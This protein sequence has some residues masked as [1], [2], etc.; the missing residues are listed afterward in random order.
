[1]SMRGSPVSDLSPE[2]IFVGR[3]R[4]KVHVQSSKPQSTEALQFCFAEHQLV[5]WMHPSCFDKVESRGCSWNTC[6]CGLCWLLGLT[7]LA[8]DPFPFSVLHFIKLLAGLLN[9]WSSEAGW[10]AV[11][12]VKVMVSICSNST[13]I[14]KY[15]PHILKLSWTH[16]NIWPSILP[17]TSPDHHPINVLE[18]NRR[19]HVFQR[20]GS[21]NNVFAHPLI[22]VHAG[23]CI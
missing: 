19:A 10:D 18:S 12:F 17:C 13:R 20:A 5:L 22:A 16:S 6:P 15:Q 14:A 4:A 1:M 7:W 11:A 8:W 9:S 2:C 23:Y 21:S 3:L